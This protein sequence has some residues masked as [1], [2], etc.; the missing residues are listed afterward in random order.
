[1][2]VTVKDNILKSFVFKII[3]WYICHFKFPY[4]GEKYFS[5]LLNKLK[6]S[7]QTFLKKLH[8][9]QLI[10]LVPQDH[11]QK[12][13]L[14]YG[15]YE[16]N[17]ILLW[18]KLIKDDSIV[19]DIGANIGYYSI[20]AANKA[21]H[22]EVHAF[23]PISST[24]HALQ[25]NI[26]LNNLKNVIVNQNGVSNAPG[27][28]DYYIS[29]TDNSG[30]SGMQPSENFSGHIEKIQTITIDQY[31]TDRNLSSV[32][33]VKIDIEGNE[34]NAL[35]GM[36]N[37]LTKFKPVLF[38]EI[39]N[40]HLTNYHATADDVFEYLNPMGY[41]SYSAKNGKLQKMEKSK[42]G[43]VIIFIPNDLS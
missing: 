12:Q 15:F 16:K 11:I 25:Q 1:M 40:E 13:I 21:K 17:Y 34:L 43:D 38:I 37:T 8:N 10:R 31:S 32:D 7:S 2:F 22:G 24:F 42:E 5:A 23:E 3:S 6:L 29:S 35:M 26:I 20:V 41:Q 4:R 28:Y 36:K 39:L 19:F 9:G 18:E 33:F 30:M 27:I 14:W